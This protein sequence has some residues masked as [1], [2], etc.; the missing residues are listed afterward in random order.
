MPR[1]VR[2]LALATLAACSGN[3]TKVEDAA[4]QDLQARLPGRYDNSAQVRVD[5]RTQAMQPQPPVDLLIVP[6]NAAFIGKSVFYVRETASGDVHRVLSQFIWVIGRTVELHEGAHNGSDGK[7]HAEGRLEQ[8]IY[9]FK[10][11]QR[12]LRAGEQPEM[13]ESLLPADLQR[14]TGCELLWTRSDTGFSAQRRSLGC[15]PETRYEGQLLEQRIE[16]TGN[17]LSMLEQQITPDGLVAAPAGS[18]DDW[19]RFV[20][21]GAAN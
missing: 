18:G 7:A 16:L 11:P 19:Y 14:L 8:H 12:W 4:L 21:H 2:L 1:C 6:A 13:L 20:R 9:V 10:E 5:Q 15:N 3:Q 17:Q